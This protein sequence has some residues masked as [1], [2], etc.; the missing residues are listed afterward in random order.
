MCQGKYRLKLI[1]LFTPGMNL[2]G[3]IVALG[4][5]T[6]GPAIRSRL[7]AS[8]RYGAFAEYA[9]AEADSLQPVVVVMSVAEATA[10]LSAYRTAFASLVRRANLQPGEAVLMHGASR[11]TGLATL[12]FAKF[13]GATV[14]STSLS[15]A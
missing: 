13:L 8:I 5:C 11:G 1:L 10:Y 7:V 14:I 3:E 2:T 4:K 6:F 9:L 12:D 15:D